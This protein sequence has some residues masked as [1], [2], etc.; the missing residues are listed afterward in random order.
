MNGFTA[1]CYYA[2]IRKQ[3]TEKISQEN[4]YKFTRREWQ[5]LQLTAQNYLTRDIA[6]KLNISERTVNYH[7][8]HVNKKLG[9]NSKYQSI[10]KALAEGLLEI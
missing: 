9:T 6:K 4:K 8:Q 10:I 1:Y 3:L 5:C 7:I 2:E